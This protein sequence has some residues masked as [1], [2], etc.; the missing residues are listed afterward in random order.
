MAEQGPTNPVRAQAIARQ[1]ARA[2]MSEQVLQEKRAEGG[3]YTPRT[4]S[5][6]KPKDLRAPKRKA[7]PGT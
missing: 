5:T 2:L 4:S 6:R 3:G 7:K 1:D